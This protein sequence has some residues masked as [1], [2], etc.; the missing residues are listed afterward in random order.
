MEP[1]GPEYRSVTQR[2]RVR[3]A[4][5]ANRLVLRPTT[6]CGLSGDMDIASQLRSRSVR[7]PT[8]HAAPP[9]GHRLRAQ[10]RQC[11]DGISYRAILGA[12][13]S[14]IHRAAGGRGERYE[15]RTP[16]VA[17]FV[18]PGSHLATPP[19]RRGRPLSASLA[20]KPI[21]RSNMSS[22]FA[23]RMS[24]ER[25][26]ETRA[27]EPR[28]GPGSSHWT[29]AVGREAHWQRSSTREYAR[30][31]RSVFQGIATRISSRTTRT[32]AILIAQHRGPQ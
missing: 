9:S 14:G 10:W 15:P 18:Q 25:V 22:S 30:S 17:S 16:G 2:S 28:R 13:L 11:G 27:G 24:S 4:R 5:S 21:E 32:H 31:L 19:P 6:M 8:R 7:R 1:C 20:R 29:V 26:F 3:S 12:A 23:R